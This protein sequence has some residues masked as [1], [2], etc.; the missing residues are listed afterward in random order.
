MKKI[1]NSI[2]LVGFVAFSAIA[3]QNVNSGVAQ[4]ATTSFTP[5]HEGPFI[6]LERMA[7]DYG[8]LN[9]GDNGTTEIKFKNTGSEPLI[10]LNVHSGCACAGATWSR[11]PIMPGQ[12]SVIVVRYDTNIIGR[13][14]RVF[15]ITTNSVGGNERVFFRLSG[16]VQPRA[17]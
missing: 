8:V 7:H 10:L 16:Q 2:V 1:F 3:Q 9:Q 17:R 11:E 6:Q 14:G 4:V 15:T 5:T 13:I 12:E